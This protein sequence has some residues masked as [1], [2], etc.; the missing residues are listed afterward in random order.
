MLNWRLKMTELWDALSGRKT[1]LGVFIWLLVRV[2]A[3]VDLISEENA[4]TWVTVA[5]SVLGVGI[6]HKISKKG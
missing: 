4:G 6:L 2:L 3:D 5:E 1:Y